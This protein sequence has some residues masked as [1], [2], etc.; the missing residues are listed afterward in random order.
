MPQRH[1]AAK[2][3]RAGP[4]PS[5]MAQRPG[6]STPPR[7]GDADTGRGPSIESPDRRR[8]AHPGQECVFCAYDL[9]G[10]PVDGSCPECG[11]AVRLTVAPEWIRTSTRQGLRR[12]AAACT[13]AWVLPLFATGLVLMLVAAQVLRVP[14]IH[15][16]AGTFCLGLSGIAAATWSTMSWRRVLTAEPGSPF[17]PGPV[18]VLCVLS[19]IVLSLGALTIVVSTLMSMRG[20]DHPAFVLGGLI[21]CFAGGPAHLALAMRGLARRFESMHRTR[22]ARWARLWGWCVLGPAVMFASFSAGLW[23]AL[24]HWDGGPLSA[25]EQFIAGAAWILFFVS[26]IPTVAALIGGGMLV[27]EFRRHVSAALLAQVGPEMQATDSGLPAPSV[28]GAT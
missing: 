12:I 25:A 18:Q 3:D 2:R 15:G 6:P 7:V 14:A 22:A 4:Y 19:G 9:G 21:A 28:D 23:I 16:V 26:W 11:R 5:W 24:D 17:R 27:R 8:S 1:R 10:L 13:G 20:W